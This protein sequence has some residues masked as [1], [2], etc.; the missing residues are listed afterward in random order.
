MARKSAV[1]GGEFKIAHLRKGSHWAR[2]LHFK[3]RAFWQV[4]QQIRRRLELLAALPF[5]KLDTL[6]L[7]AATKEIGF[8][9]KSRLSIRLPLNRTKVMSDKPTVLILCTV[10]NADNRRHK[11]L[12]ECQD[13]QE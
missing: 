12:Q 11:A 13:W 3:R 10:H 5:E 7:E 2:N 8:A 4:A 9:R 1:T 6:R